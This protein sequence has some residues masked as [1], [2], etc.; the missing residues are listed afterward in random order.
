MC[1][2]LPERRPKETERDQAKPNVYALTRTPPELTRAWPDL[3]ECHELS[4]VLSD[5]AESNRTH[6]MQLVVTL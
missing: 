1:Q 4:P 3:A 5:I 2:S 6:S